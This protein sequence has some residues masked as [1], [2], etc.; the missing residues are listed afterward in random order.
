MW[1]N[2][3]ERPGSSAHLN[4][5]RTPNHSTARGGEDIL[6][7]QTTSDIV[8]HHGLDVLGLD[9][10][11]SDGQCNIWLIVN[12]AELHN[13]MT[14]EMKFQTVKAVHDVGKQSPCIPSS[15]GTPNLPVRASIIRV[16]AA[17]D[18]FARCGCG[19]K[20]VIEDACFALT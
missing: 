19:D 2:T 4:K 6:N 3:R 10:L 5:H 8:P 13:D 14:Y 16:T 18:S 7:H 20:I 12:I 1:A 11:I 15:P 17:S 9:F